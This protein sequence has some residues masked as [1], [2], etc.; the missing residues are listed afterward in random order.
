MKTTV[1]NLLVLEITFDF[2][3]QARV[4]GSRGSWSVSVQTVDLSGEDMMH[5]GSESFRI[6]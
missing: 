6:S 1:L 3:T 4:A 5:D 2:M